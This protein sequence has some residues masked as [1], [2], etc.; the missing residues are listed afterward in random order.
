MQSVSAGM[1]KN[2]FDQTAFNTKFYFSEI[3][4]NKN[5]QE[6]YSMILIGGLLSK[7]KKQK[8]LLTKTSAYQILEFCSSGFKSFWMLKIFVTISNY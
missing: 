4:K 2:N 3:V 1:I 6:N 7:N 8:T 5:I